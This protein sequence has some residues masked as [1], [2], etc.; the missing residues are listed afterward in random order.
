MYVL[1]LIKKCLSWDSNQQQDLGKPS[2]KKIAMPNYLWKAAK[3]YH[4]VG[5]KTQCAFR[6][7]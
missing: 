3:L 7:E 6:R 5:E 2:Q 1:I 4:M